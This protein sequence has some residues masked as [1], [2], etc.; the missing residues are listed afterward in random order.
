[1]IGSFVLLIAGS[2][3]LAFGL[4]IIIHFIRFRARAESLLGHVKLIEKY[5]GYTQSSSGSGRVATTYYRPVVEYEYDGKTYTTVGFSVNEMRHKPG[6]KIRVLLNVSPDGKTIHAKVDEPFLHF[7]MG[8]IFSLFGIVAIGIYIFA[9]NGESIFLSLPAILIIAGYLISN[10]VLNHKGTSEKSDEWIRKEDS[11]L[12]ETRTDYMEEISSHNIVGN[13]IAFG[14]LICSVSLMYWG[15]SNLSPDVT[16]LMIQDIGSFWNK[17]VN[18]EF[19][20]SNK[21]TLIIIG[22]GFFFFLA[23]LRSIYYVNKKFGSAMRI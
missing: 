5:I 21:D 6:Q 3:F 7:L 23:S 1:M 17:L 9:M 8:G 19:S 20:S 2:I 10:A 16:A 14:L 18:G 11:K 4:N 22:I 13:I 12:I 15:Y